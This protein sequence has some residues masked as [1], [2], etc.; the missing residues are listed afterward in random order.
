[1]KNCYVV[2][3]PLIQHKCTRLRDK[4]TEPAEFRQLVEDVSLLMAYEVTRNFR[5]VPIEVETPM[6][7]TSSL[8]L[9]EPVALVSILRA[10]NAMLTGMTKLLPEA[11][12]GFVG[13]YRDKFIQDTV[14]YYFRLPE[15]IEGKKVLLLDCILS[16]GETARA[17]VS[18]LKDYGVKDIC[19]VS[20]LC[21]QQGL[22]AFHQAHPDTLVYTTQ[23]E[24]E[25]DEQGYLVPGIG[26]VGDRLYGS[27]DKRL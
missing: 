23:V 21:S 25:V 3:H 7:K 16:T 10:G 2:E 9:D 1:M 22:E 18:R 27:F 4:A 24:P 14:E 11:P 5:T 20:L 13:I 19:F 8:I 12:I 6:A 15:G 26:D 17:A